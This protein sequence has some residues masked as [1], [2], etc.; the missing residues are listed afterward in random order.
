MRGEAGWEWAGVDL[1]SLNP[2][3]PSPALW[4]GTKI[5]PHPRPTTYA[6]RGKPAWGETGWGGL[7]GAGWGKIDIPTC[8]PPIS[9]Y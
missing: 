9:H 2:F 6:G 4:Y 1:K 3:S 7:S 8:G 5:L